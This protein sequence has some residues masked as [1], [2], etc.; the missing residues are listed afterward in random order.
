MANTILYL[1]DIQILEI[2]KKYTK[3]KRNLT[4]QTE[5]D[6]IL[7]SQVTHTMHTSSL[8]LTYNNIQGE[9]NTT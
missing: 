8:S 3:E 2:Q 9:I 6:D 5:E 4:K 1:R 7:L